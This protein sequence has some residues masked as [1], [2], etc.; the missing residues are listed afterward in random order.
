MLTTTANAGVTSVSMIANSFTERGELLDLL[1]G[2]NN[3]IADPQ[4]DIIFHP[5][6]Q[7]KYLTISILP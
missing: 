7:V 5:I 1:R 4:K 3:A 2:K 6:G